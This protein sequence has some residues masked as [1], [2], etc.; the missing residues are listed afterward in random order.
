MGNSLCLKKLEGK[1]SQLRDLAC[2]HSLRK[3]KLVLVET[4]ISSTPYTSYTSIDRSA[5]SDGGGSSSLKMSKLDCD[6]N[7]MNGSP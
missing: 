7:L 1:I 2:L 3:L 6:D 5:V 4:S